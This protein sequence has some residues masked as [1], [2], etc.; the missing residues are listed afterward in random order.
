VQGNQS[1]PPGLED[2]EE[3]YPELFA[4]H[5]DPITLAVALADAPAVVRELVDL[6]QAHGLDLA[7]DGR[8][9][10]LKEADKGQAA[11]AMEALTRCVDIVADHQEELGAWLAPLIR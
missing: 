11:Q 10:V 1:G 6:A 3:L 8:A 4:L 5:G 9:V 2:W 7:W